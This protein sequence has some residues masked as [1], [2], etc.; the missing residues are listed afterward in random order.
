MPEQ[1]I[2]PLS[3]ILLGAAISQ[4]DDDEL[5]ESM[6]LAAS[7]LDEGLASLPDEERAKLDEQVEG[8]KVVALDLLEAHGADG[9]FAWAKMSTL[10]LAAQGESTTAMSLIL[11]VAHR[12][13]K[14]TLN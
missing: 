5:I 12:A 9:L 6:A 8:L 3:P 14:T 1:P 7:K 2:E 13:W 10:T 11:A 4:M